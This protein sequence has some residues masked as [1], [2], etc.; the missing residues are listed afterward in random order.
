MMFRVLASFALA[1][2]MAMTVTAAYAPVISG[3]FTS[4]ITVEEGTEKSH[5][6]I[7]SDV[8]GRRWFRFLT[9]LNETTYVF[10]PF[11]RNYIM[12]YTIMNS[13][14]TCQRTDNAEVENMFGELLTA[15]SGKGSCAKGASGT[16]YANA[17]ALGLPA[18]PTKSY[19]L[20]GST[21]SYVLDGST[22]TMFKDFTA[23]RPV[24]FPFE[25]IA[26]QVNACAN[27]CL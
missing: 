4:N 25:T 12:T 11:G 20:S 21:P 18:V 6:Y 2:M 19:C 24:N 7:I 27:A 15:Q 9:E 17:K 3:D 5:G 14:C 23:G 8:T 26:T 1:S 22:Y 10:Q 13:G 16:L